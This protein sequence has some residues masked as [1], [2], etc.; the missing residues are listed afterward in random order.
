MSDSKMKAL[1]VVRR[2]EEHEMHA[3][4]QE[5]DRQVGNDNVAAFDASRKMDDA[6]EN[7]DNLAVVGAEHGYTSNNDDDH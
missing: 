6:A 7:A 3:Q 2:E 1:S 4:Q 5:A